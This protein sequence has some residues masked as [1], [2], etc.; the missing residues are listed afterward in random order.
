MLQ[1]IV[2]YLLYAELFS[3]RGLGARAQQQNWGLD[4]QIARQQLCE[5]LDCTTVSRGHVT[6]VFPQVTSHTP[7]L[8]PLLRYAW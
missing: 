6:S 3:H 1:S 4:E 5:R 8:S 7:A 2:A